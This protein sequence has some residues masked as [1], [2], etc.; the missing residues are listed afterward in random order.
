MNRSETQ[1]GV[2]ILVALGVLA[3]ITA[4][5]LFFISYIT[6]TKSSAKNTSELT[7][8]RMFIASAVQRV[9]AGMSVYAGSNTKNYYDVTSLCNISNDPLITT[10]IGSDSVG[11]LLATIKDGITYYSADEFN[12]THVNSRPQWQYIKDSNGKIINRI[13]FIIIPETGQINPSIYV[14]SGVSSYKNDVQA[15]SENDMRNPFAVSINADGDTMYG[16]AGISANEINLK[17]LIAELVE[18]SAVDEYLDGMSSNLSTSGKMPSK[19]AYS[20]YDIDYFFTNLEIEED[21][22]NSFHK[23]FSFIQQSAPEA[24]WIA[25]D[26][27]DTTR[28][29]N[30]MFNRFNLKRVDWDSLSVVDI[31]TES[32][33]FSSTAELHNGFVE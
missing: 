25:R 17:P 24:F 9:Q 31:L 13:S 14:D 5:S 4:L 19:P 2:A 20:W 21:S 30:E 3:V 16:R 15:V 22:K 29:E 11:E 18:A 8:A 26:S 12:N 6:I 7:S 23:Q 33:Q 1:T 28:N 32:S 27:A 10:D